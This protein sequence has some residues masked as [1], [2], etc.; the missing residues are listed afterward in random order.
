[1]ASLRIDSAISECYGLS[2][3]I[4]SKL[5]EAD[6][7]K[8]NYK[9]ITNSSKAIKQGDLISVRGYGRFI[10]EEVIGETRKGRVRIQI[11]K[12]K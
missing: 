12:N 8:L 3:T 11:K 10:I 4:S 7:V 6:K 5:I 2:R 9:V 1:M